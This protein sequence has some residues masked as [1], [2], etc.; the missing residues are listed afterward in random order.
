MCR[1]TIVVTDSV[2]DEMTGILL[3]IGFLIFKI[4]VLSK[5]IAFEN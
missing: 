5:Y 1:G 3:F 4:Q 2:Q